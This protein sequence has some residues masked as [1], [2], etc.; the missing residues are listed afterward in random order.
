MRTRSAGVL[1]TGLSQLPADLSRTA[2]AGPAA[3]CWP[4][5]PGRIGKA[6]GVVPR[7][8]TTPHSGRRAPCALGYT[9]ASTG[10]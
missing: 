5:G 6:G 10:W 9:P 4:A 1:P 3:G 8:G 2:A 7:R